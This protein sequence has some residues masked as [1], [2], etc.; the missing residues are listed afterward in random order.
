MEKKWRSVL[1]TITHQSVNGEARS[2][3]GFLNKFQ[4]EPGGMIVVH[5]TSDGE[6]L[7]APVT[8]DVLLYTIVAA[9]IPKDVWLSSF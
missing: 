7:M 1:I 6:G 2:L 8:L 9:A 3:S 4:I 5:S